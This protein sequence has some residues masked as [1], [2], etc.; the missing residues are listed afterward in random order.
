MGDSVNCINDMSPCP[1]TKSVEFF[2]AMN[3]FPIDSVSDAPASSMPVGPH[4]PASN[5]IIYR[6]YYNSP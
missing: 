2:Y 3:V 1:I 4:A 6:A 5:N